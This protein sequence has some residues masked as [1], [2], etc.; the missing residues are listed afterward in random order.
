MTGVPDYV[1]EIV[2][3]YCAG[4][5]AEAERAAY[6]RGVAA[7]E[8]RVAAG[9]RA[10]AAF[11]PP[12]RSDLP[13]AMLS[14]EPPDDF[15]LTTALDDLFGAD[16]WSDLDRQELVRLV[17][18]AVQEALAA[19][20]RDPEPVLDMLRAVAA[21]GFD[22]AMEGGG[23]FR[24]WLSWQAVP[25][26]NPR[27]DFRFKAVDHDSGVEKY[28]DKAITALQQHNRDRFA[29]NPG[30]AD[31]AMQGQPYDLEGPATLAEHNEAYRK[32]KAAIA[33]LRERL[34]G[35]GPVRPGD[36]AEF[37]THLPLMTAAE[38]RAVRKLLLAGLTKRVR[39]GQS[40]AQRVTS[41]A[42]A[43]NRLREA[44]QAISTDVLQRAEEFGHDITPAEEQ[45]A[46]ADVADEI[47]ADADAME[48]MPT[49]EDGDVLLE[50][51]LPPDVA[52]P[53]NDQPTDQPP[54]PPTQG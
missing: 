42:D 40:K 48:Q 39:A 44:V 50:F 35:G 1:R 23:R 33:G 54:A 8:E 6:E 19:R 26:K 38:L 29:F 20:G 25:L 30:A 4:R 15:S 28:G 22:D 37:Q 47:G 7:G 49:D 43:L 32:A 51:D 13:P 16:R 3:E 36:L 12:V 27:G 2:E 41:L 9:V 10:L 34:S 17:M 14:D 53:Q 18:A 45:Q 24:T 31:P 52:A 5:V 21:S 11:A 46:E